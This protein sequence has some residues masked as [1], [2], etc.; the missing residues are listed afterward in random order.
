MIQ[1]RVRAGL[2]RAK[3]DGKTLGRPRTDKAIEAAIRR[4]PQKG[5]TGMHKIAAAFGVG[6]GTVQRIKA[7]MSG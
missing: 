5:D 3:E 6:T 1:E 7:E 4:A 2:A